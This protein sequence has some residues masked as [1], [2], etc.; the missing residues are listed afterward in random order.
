M[1]ALKFI[2]GEEGYHATSSSNRK[3]GRRRCKHH[4][5]HFNHHNQHHI[6]SGGHLNFLEPCSDNRE[7]VED[8]FG[9]SLFDLI[10][11]SK[12]NKSNYGKDSQSETWG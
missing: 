9:L 4:H 7:T 10:L 1:P 3:S 12:I 2:E 6:Q 5:H 11:I 8:T